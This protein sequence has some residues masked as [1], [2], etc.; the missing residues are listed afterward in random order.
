[1]KRVQRKHKGSLDILKLEAA[2][3]VVSFIKYEYTVFPVKGKGFSISMI[4]EIVIRSKQY[5]N[6][7]VKLP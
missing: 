5:I 2:Y 6:S 7:L 4:N 1:M 3:Q